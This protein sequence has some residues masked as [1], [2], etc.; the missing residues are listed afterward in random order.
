M[1]WTPE[2]HHQFVEAVAH[3][4]EKGA[5]PKAIVQLM[6]VDGL[7]RENVA[8]HLQ[9]YRLYLKR[10]STTATATPPPPPPLPASR[11]AF[12]SSPARSS[13]VKHS[14]SCAKDG[15]TAFS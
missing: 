3:L 7:T 13:D 10:T 6:N 8:S 4:G 5:M 2:L 14:R 11:S 12:L 9:K 1:V 15:R